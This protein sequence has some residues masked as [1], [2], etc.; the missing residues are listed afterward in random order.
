MAYVKR[1]AAEWRGRRVSAIVSIRDLI[2]AIFSQRKERLIIAL[3]IVWGTWF[4]DVALV[5]RC[6]YRGKKGGCKL[7]RVKR[8]SGAFRLVC[9]HFQSC[10]HQSRRKLGNTQTSSEVF[11]RFAVWNNYPQIVLARPRG[12]REF[13]S[14]RSQS[15]SSCWVMSTSIVG[16]SI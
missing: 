2:T 14:V 13:N 15:L 16:E 3:K 12:A 9:H 6:V 1:N 11:H 8:K 7:R 10:R 5:E 4:H